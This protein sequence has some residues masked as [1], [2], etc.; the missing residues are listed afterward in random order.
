LVDHV[1]Q[2]ADAQSRHMTLKGPASDG[3][4]QIAVG[5][6]VTNGREAEF[7]QRMHAVAQNDP[8]RRSCLPAAEV[9]ERAQCVAQ[10]ARGWGQR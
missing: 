3:D 7:A 6:D 9:H 4:F 8:S 1:L 5:F 2:D 10:Y